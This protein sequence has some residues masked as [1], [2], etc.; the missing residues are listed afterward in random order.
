MGNT[1]VIYTSN[2]SVTQMG[3]Q[4]SVFSQAMGPIHFTVFKEENTMSTIGWVIL[5]LLIAIPDFVHRTKRDGLR[6]A[7]QAYFFATGIFSV[8]VV[9]HAAFGIVGLIALLALMI[10]A[11]VAIW[12]YRRPERV[13]KNELLQKW[14]AES[15]K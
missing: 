6:D 1:L 4:I 9:L 13:R 14:E 7:I 3:Y 8:G 5:V 12:V 15:D 2:Q 11:T 10:V